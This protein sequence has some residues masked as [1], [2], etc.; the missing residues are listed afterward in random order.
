MKEV[1]NFEIFERGT[2]SI[3]N[4]IDDVYIQMLCALSVCRRL[5]GTKLGGILNVK[6]F[7][8][9]QEDEGIDELIFRFNAHALQKFTRCDCVIARTPKTKLFYIFPR[10]KSCYPMMDPQFILIRLFSN[11]GPGKT[12]KFLFGLFV[13]RHA[14]LSTSILSPI[15]KPSGC[16]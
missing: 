8:F 6:V 13:L 11:A 14:I 16:T 5:Y 1:S 4:S 10:V 12:T 2:T 3:S 9:V 15:N 7:H